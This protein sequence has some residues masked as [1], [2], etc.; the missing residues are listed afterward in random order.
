MAA[1]GNRNSSSE[2]G[3]G[4]KQNSHRSVCNVFDR[5]YESEKYMRGALVVSI[6]K[7]MLNCFYDTIEEMSWLNG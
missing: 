7:R 3:Y 5:E 2:S 1:R 6:V 4:R